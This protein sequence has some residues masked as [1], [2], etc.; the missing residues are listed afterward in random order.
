MRGLAAHSNGFQT[1]RA[2]AILMSD[3]RHHRPARRLPPQGAVPAPD[4]ALRQDPPKGPTRQ[5]RTRRWT[6]CRWAGRPIRTTCSSTMHGEPVRIDKALLLGIPAVGARPDAQRHHQRLARRPVPDRHAADLHGQHGLE[7][8]DE[9]VEVRK[10]LNDKDENG[11]YKIPFL[12][13]ADAFQS[14]MTP[15]P[16]WCCRTPPTSSA[17]T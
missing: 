14:E 13:V 17:T 7:L 1:I 10:M 3:P 6:A 5:A 16:T 9:H 15:S 2:L 12:I 4:P 8:D 11:E